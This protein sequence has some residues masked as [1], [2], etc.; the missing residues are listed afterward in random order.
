MV[1]ETTFPDDIEKRMKQA[2][3]A[4]S[5][6]GDEDNMQQFRP[7]VNAM[8]LYVEKNRRRRGV[9]RRSGLKGQVFHIFAKAER[10]FEIIMHDGEHD[11]EEII[12]LINYAAFA[13]RLST[14]EVK[15]M[16][17]TWPW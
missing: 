15:D 5:I 14:G 4:L 9:W 13:D 1:M 10:L 2:L 11:P 17:G 7:M 3:L 12:D 16:K 6:R 8:F